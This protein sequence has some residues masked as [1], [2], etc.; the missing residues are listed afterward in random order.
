MYVRL[1]SGFIMDCYGTPRE[2]IHPYDDV[3]RCAEIHPM[4]EI[5]WL[6]M[7]WCPRCG[8][9]GRRSSWISG[10][11]RMRSVTTI[12]TGSSDVRYAEDR[13]GYDS[14]KYVLTSDHVEYGSGYV[15]QV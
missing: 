7:S 4:G 6:G 5:L 13:I 10:K 2:P 15:R 12:D 11:F 14:I 1:S 8:R 3:I 9:R